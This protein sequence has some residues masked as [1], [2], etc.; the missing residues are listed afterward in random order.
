MKITIINTVKYQTTMMVNIG[1][2]HHKFQEL[3]V[4]MFLLKASLTY[5]DQPPSVLV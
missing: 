3:E 1:C 4:G 5:L 2:Y